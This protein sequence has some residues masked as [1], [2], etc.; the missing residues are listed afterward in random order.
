MVKPLS[1]ETSMKSKTLQIIVVREHSSKEFVWD[2][3]KSQA[4]HKQI[5]IDHRILILY[6]L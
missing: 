6:N 2:S 5:K 1:G 4:S 3:Q